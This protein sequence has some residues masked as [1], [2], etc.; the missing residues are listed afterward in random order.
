[1]KSAAKLSLV[2]VA[3]G[4][5]ALAAA[6]AAAPGARGPGSATVSARGDFVLA[7]APGPAPV[8]PPARERRPDGGGSGGAPLKGPLVNEEP[9]P[10]G[11]PPRLAVACG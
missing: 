8:T 5:A 11:P 3:V 9:E 7:Q 1:M 2:A 6:Q 10:N 4:L